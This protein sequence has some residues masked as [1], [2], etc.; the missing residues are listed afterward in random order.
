MWIVLNLFLE[1]VIKRK[2]NSCDGR[3]FNPLSL[4]SDQ[5]NKLR[6][7][8]SPLQTDLFFSCH[9]TRPTTWQTDFNVWKYIQIVLC[10]RYPKPYLLQ[11][12]SNFSLLYQSFVKQSGH[13]NYGHDHTSWIWLTFY[14]LL[15]TTSVGHEWGQQ[16]RI[17]ILILGFKGVNRLFVT[18]WS[19]RSNASKQTIQNIMMGPVEFSLENTW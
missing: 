14:Q 4:K 2:S 18:T 12:A 19:P 13:E 9:N 7:Y 3:S 6:T 17:Q 10:V 5:W 15:P 1:A 16:M 11:S 8:Q